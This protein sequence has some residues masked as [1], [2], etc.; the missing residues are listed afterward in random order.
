VQ[1]LIFSSQ[2]TLEWDASAS[3]VV[4]NLYR[5]LT[6][7]L[8]TLGFGDCLQPDVPAPTTADSD[9]PSSGAAF[10]YLV[11]TENSLQEHGTKGFQ[12]DGT[13]RMGAICP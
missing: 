6:S 11:T 12:S 5:G 3:S 13:E 7:D 4:Y 10:F 8:P 2:D 1:N 9:E